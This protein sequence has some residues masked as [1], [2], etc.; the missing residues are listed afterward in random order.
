MSQPY[1][2]TETP[3]SKKQRRQRQQRNRPVLVSPA[4][5]ESTPARN[6]D[7]LTETTS[8]VVA[9]EPVATIEKATPVRRPSRLPGFFSKVARS[10]QEPTTSEADVVQARLARAARTKDSSQKIAAST[11]SQDVAKV[12]K[13]VKDTKAAAQQPPKLFKSRH[14]IGMGIYLLAAEFLLPEEA[15]FFTVY[16]LDKTLATFP[17]FGFNAV[18]STSIIANIASLLLMLYLLV[19]FDL[20]PSSL[21]SA[22][23]QARGTAARTRSTGQ[24]NLTPRQAP[25]AVRPGVQGEHDDLYQAYRI[26]QRREKKR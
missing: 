17:L 8:P 6:T 21:N 7:A 25:P 14:I 24:N 13:D 22:S 3:L 20:L 5:R 19:K 2:T 23:R 12:T 15:R 9:A 16:K 26:N 11:A 18:I 4:E 1:S 10:E